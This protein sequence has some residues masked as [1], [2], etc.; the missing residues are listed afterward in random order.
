MS[1]FTSKIKIKKKNQKK[2]KTKTRINKRYKKNQKGGANGITINDTTVTSLSGPKSFYYLKPNLANIDL[3]ELKYFPLIVLFGDLHRSKEFSCEKCTCSE[4]GKCCYAISDHSFLHLLDT[5]GDDQN[6]VDFFT[7]T[8]LM[9]TGTKFKNGYMEDFTTKDMVTCYQ[10]PLRGTDHY[11]KCPTKNIRWQ[12]GDPR[13]A[14]DMFTKLEGYDN[15]YYLRYGDD[16]GSVENLLKQQIN[17]TEYI[18]TISKKYRDDS[19]FEF[20][21]SEL[22]DLLYLIVKDLCDLYENKVRGTLDYNIK[23]FNALLIKSK[24]TFDDILLILSDLYDDS[25]PFS[26]DFDKFSKTFFSKL[27]RGNSLIFK[28]IMKQDYAPFQDIS[29][30]SN[31]YA[32]SL[33]E[34]FKRTKENFLPKDFKIFLVNI[35]DIVEFIDDYVHTTDIELLKLVKDC[36]EVLWVLQLAIGSPLLDVY[37]ITRILK[38]PEGEGGKRSSLTFGYFGHGHVQNIVKTLLDTEKYTLVN[39]L[40]NADY[41]R[42]LVFPFAINLT[43]AIKFKDEMNTPAAV[44]TPVVSGRTLATPFTLRTKKQGSPKTLMQ[45]MYSLV[46]HPR[47]GSTSTLKREVN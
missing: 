30:W 20:Q 29:Y 25:K 35:K 19:Y 24:L 13:Q 32:T 27:N 16:E 38:K 34:S 23:K 1:S 12:A 11:N 28:Q 41:K 14:G 26:L 10:K 7:E 42:C 3:S 2:R 5:L 31:I 43:R 46:R 39:S 9:G 47:W 44:H 33:R 15:A 17:G 36:R 45:K 8:F 6:P 22:I 21:F 18:K 37:T 4:N 40:V